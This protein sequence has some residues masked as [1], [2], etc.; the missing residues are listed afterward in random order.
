MRY[1]KEDEQIV[2]NIYNDIYV[3]YGSGTGVLFGIPSSL[4]SS[5]KS[6]IKAVI[7]SQSVSRSL[8]FVRHLENH[9]EVINAPVNTGIPMCKICNKTIGQ[10]YKEMRE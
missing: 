7:I 2:E 10:I 8:T 9:D 5:V 3:C 1:T 4:K 6:I